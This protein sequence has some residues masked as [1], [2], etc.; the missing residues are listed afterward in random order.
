MSIA[1]STPIA[2]IAAASARP[3]ASA[4]SSFDVSVGLASETIVELQ[5]KANI[6]DQAAIRELVRRASLDQVATDSE[7]SQGPAS[8]PEPGKGTQIDQT[9]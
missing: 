8:S 3:A 1:M 6:G 5:T 9:A 2:A 4:S 7:T